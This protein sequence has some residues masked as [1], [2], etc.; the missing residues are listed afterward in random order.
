[1]LNIKKKLYH[2]PNIYQLNIVY[3]EDK[4]IDKSAVDWAANARDNNEI[5][6]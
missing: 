5:T 2:I 6:W 1:M 3:T 4:Y